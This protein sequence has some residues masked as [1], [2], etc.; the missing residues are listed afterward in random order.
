MTEAKIL[1]VPVVT[2]NYPCAYESILDGE[3]GLIDSF[4]NVEESIFRM[5]TN[6]DGIYSRIKEVLRRYKYNNQELLL[7]LYREVLK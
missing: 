7:H 4:E 2:T 5:V 6:Q 3:E 1:G